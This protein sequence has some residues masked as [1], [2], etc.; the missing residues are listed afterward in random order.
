MERR[1]FVVCNHKLFPEID[2]LLMEVEVTPM[3]IV[4]KLMKSEEADITCWFPP[5]I[6]VK[7]IGNGS[8]GAEKENQLM[9]DRKSVV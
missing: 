4:E 6:Y 3:E 1:V 9:K 2:K 7:M 5:S 8:N